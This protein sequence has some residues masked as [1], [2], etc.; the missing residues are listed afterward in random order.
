MT[1]EDNGRGFDPAARDRTRN[2]LSNMAHR[3]TEVGGKCQIVSR[4]GAGCRVELSAKVSHLSDHHSSW[5][6]LRAHSSST[7]GKKE[8][9]P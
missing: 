4:P 9:Q 7:F 5:W 3:M 1:V 2:G 6:R 8:I